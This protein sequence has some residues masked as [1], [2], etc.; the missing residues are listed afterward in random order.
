MKD[1]DKIAARLDE[2][3]HTGTATPQLSGEVELTEAEAYDIQKRSVARRLGRG[4]ELVGI[5]MG[6]TSRAKMRQ[7]GVHEMIWG[8]LTS[9]MRVEDGGAISHGKYVHARAEPEV[10]FLLKQRIDH[11]I[12]VAEAMNAV[13][14]VA[15]AIEVIDSRYENFKFNLSDV[16]AD[17]ASSSGF[18]L[19]PWCR[20][21]QDVS[22]LGIVFELDGRPVKLGSS[23]AILGH[24]GRALAAA[25][26]LV[27]RHGL[28]LEAGWVVMAGGATEAVHLSVGNYVRST[29]ESL[30]RV[31]FSV[32]A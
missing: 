25:S 21:D 23:A 31:G 22:N 28:A 8:H 20:S 10:A 17:N 19:G 7:M 27:T 30:G 15:P 13:E 18:V 16:V 5:K 26:R 24:P 11:E 14:A 32:E 4:A 12:S 3:A 9:D 29:V 6:F 2:A 1:L